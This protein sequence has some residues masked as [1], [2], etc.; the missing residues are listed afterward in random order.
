[1]RQACKSRCSVNIERP[2]AI[3]LTARPDGTPAR[4]AGLWTST[5]A[6]DF[7]LLLFYVGTRLAMA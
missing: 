4:Q 5:A 2:A 7:V 1:M 6:F 3:V